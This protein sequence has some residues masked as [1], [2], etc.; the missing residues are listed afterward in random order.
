MIVSTPSTPYADRDRALAELRSTNVD[1][2]SFGIA[3]LE[4]DLRL[5]ALEICR[6]ADCALSESQISVAYVEETPQW[7]PNQSF[8]WPSSGVILIS[9]TITRTGSDSSMATEHGCETSLG[10]STDL[11]IDAP[12]MSP[13]RFFLPRNTWIGLYRNSKNV[14]T[15]HQLSA[16]AGHIFLLM[17]ERH[18]WRRPNGLVDRLVWVTCVG[19]AARSGEANHAKA[20]VVAKGQ[21]PE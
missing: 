4:A 1:F 5:R 18:E 19:P 11:T 6:T 21:V 2:L 7:W 8:A 17:T 10:L 13:A 15:V 9:E 3:S 12:W 20:I 14:D 16:I